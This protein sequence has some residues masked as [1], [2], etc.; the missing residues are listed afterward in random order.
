[1]NVEVPLK[2]VNPLAL[3][4]EID[5]AAPGHYQG[6]STGAKFPGVALLHFADNTPQAE[7]DAAKLAYTNHNPNTL[8]TEQRAAAAQLVAKQQL[9]Q[10]DFDALKAE[11][12]AASTLNQ[13]KQ[14]VWKLARMEWQLL[15][16]NGYVATV[17]PGE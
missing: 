15:K 16:A 10:A 17:D 11:L 5:A 2:I 1:M 13:V 12:T 6:M 4:A 8:T 3:K 9:T 7:I 14:V